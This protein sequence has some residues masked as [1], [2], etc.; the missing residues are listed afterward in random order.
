MKEYATDD[1]FLVKRP[2][3]LLLSNN[4]LLLLTKKSSSV[5]YSFILTLFIED[6]FIFSYIISTIVI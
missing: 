3:G 5:A 1:D 4:P 2:N 6:C